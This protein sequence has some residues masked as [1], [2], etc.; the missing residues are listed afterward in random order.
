V[1]SVGASWTVPRVD[2]GSSPGVAGTWIGA[3]AP[4]TNRGTP[5]IQIGVT[6][7][8]LTPTA[9]RLPGGS[10]EAF[11]STTGRGSHPQFLF[12][13][14]AGDDISASL[15][16][17]HGR[18]TLAIVDGTSGVA[19]RLSTSAEARASFN[20]ATWIQEDVRNQATGKLFTYPE[21]TPVDF[22]ELTVNTVAPAYA[23]VYSLWMSANGR[24][25]APSPLQH[26]SFTLRQ[27]Q[28]STV[29]EQYLRIA[30]R[31]D[32][33]TQAFFAQLAQWSPSTP[34]SQ[35]AAASEALLTVLRDNF[36]TLAHSRWPARVHGP[37]A[38]LIDAANVLL[39]DLAAV[40]STPATGLVAWISRFERD[41]AVIGDAGHTIRRA[42]D[43]PELE[44]SR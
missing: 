21:L 16:L 30:E 34:R 40:R 7:H 3:R 9:K 23:D 44:P 25:L 13:V 11:W 28:V 15:T 14:D 22:R 20:E 17:A 8:A 24:S 32:T 29:G 37:L 41:A 19:A 18:W 35:L 33:A 2:P 36:E 4:S 31:E 42:L 5:F 1:H 38:S 39:A 27:A 26:D 43:L 10:Y 12:P 6:E